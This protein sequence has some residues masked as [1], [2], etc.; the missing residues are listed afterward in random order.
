[1]VVLGCCRCCRCCCCCCC[2]RKTGLVFH[3][4]FKLK[5]L[6]AYA[7]HATWIIN[8]R[9]VREWVQ[10]VTN[11]YGLG[12]RFLTRYG[13]IYW[14][15]GN[16]R[17]AILEEIFVNH[18]QSIRDFVRHYHHHPPTHPLLVIELDITDPDA[19]K[20]LS[21]AFGLANES[22]W[23]IHNHNWR[24][25]SP[26]QWEKD[27]RSPDNPVAFQQQQQK[28]QGWRQ[29]SWSSSTATT[30]RRSGMTTFMKTN[31]W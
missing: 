28:G 25:N 17:H 2:F 22:C 1:M 9:P 6:H 29:S 27:E 3:N 5:E 26:I 19:G 10:S 20:I 8:V 11:W 15:I 14:T 7:P 30:S 12:D 4:I 18:L 24:R 21:V 13:I 23:G 31:L 16:R